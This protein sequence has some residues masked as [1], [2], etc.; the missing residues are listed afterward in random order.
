LKIRETLYGEKGSD[1]AFLMQ[2]GYRGR[3]P[4]LHSGGRGFAGRG[5]GKGKG[6]G[7]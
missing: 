7:H 2:S 6:K 5:K 1:K 4:F 3:K